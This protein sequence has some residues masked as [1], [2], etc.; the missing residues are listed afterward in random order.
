MATGDLL[1]NLVVYLELALQFTLKT[2]VMLV[3]IGIL[4]T[5][6]LVLAKEGN[7]EKNSI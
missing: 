3:L 4:P 1:L 5:V 2:Q 7:M 6:L